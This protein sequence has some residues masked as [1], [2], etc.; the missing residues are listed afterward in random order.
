M[1]ERYPDEYDWHGD[2]ER[3]AARRAGWTVFWLTTALLLF[4]LSIF[5]L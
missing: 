2:C 1:S 5:V 4:A 3:A